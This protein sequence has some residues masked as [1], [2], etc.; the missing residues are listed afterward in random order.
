MIVSRFTHTVK[1][2]HK[3]ELIELLKGWLDLAGLAG[4]V[5]SSRYAWETVSIDVEF[6]TD[7]D[8]AKFAADYDFS[9]PEFAEWHKKL[10][11]LREPGTTH[12]LLR[13]H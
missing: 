3:S 12:E 10:D 6:E 11:E 7:A 9:Q 13:V 1:V 2:G 5:Y 8:E 4:R